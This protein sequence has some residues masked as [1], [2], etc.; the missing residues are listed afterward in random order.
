MAAGKKT[1]GR[2]KGTLNRAT[3][4]REREIAKAAAP[5]AHPKLPLVDAVSGPNRTRP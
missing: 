3:E 4:S 5:Y 2:T 1:G